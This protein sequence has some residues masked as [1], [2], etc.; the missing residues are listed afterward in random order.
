MLL[1]NT[2][3]I[4][5]LTESRPSTPR[6]Y[7]YTLYVPPKDAHDELWE[8][9]RT[10]TEGAIE[11]FGADAAYHNSALASHLG[12]LVSGETDL[13]VEL[14]PNP[15]PSISSMPYPA[16]SSFSHS[17]EKRKRSSLSK[18]FNS[19]SDGS[20]GGSIWSRPPQPPHSTLHWAL[21]S[22]RASRLEPEVERLRLIKSPAEISLMKIAGQISGQA[23][24]EVMRF[25][26]ADGGRWKSKRTELE[27][28]KREDDLSAVF[29]YN[30]AME[31][32]ERPA[33]VPVVASG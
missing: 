12:S 23:H 1:L 17:S 19:A 28:P 16:T 14:P 29:E 32:A 13:Y 20:E 30:C 15:S 11:V 22:G 2:D 33:Y 9:A 6:G 27:R 21:K 5:S 3:L 26:S 25:A 18:L 31:G 10:G 4:S 8:G 7:H 24:T